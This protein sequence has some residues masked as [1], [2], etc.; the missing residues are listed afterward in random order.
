[1]VALVERVGDGLAEAVEGH[2]AV[3]L[4]FG[5]PLV[6]R[7]FPRLLRGDGQDGEIRAVAADLALF[8]IFPEEADELDVIEIHDV[9]LLFLPRFLGA[10]RAEWILLPRRAAAF[11]EGPKGFTG[12]NRESRSPEAAGRRNYPEAVPKERSGKKG[13][14]M[15]LTTNLFGTAAE[16]LQSNERSIIPIELFSSHPPSD[17]CLGSII[18]SV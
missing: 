1:M 10:P 7:V 17:F 6:V 13:N 5:L 15:D 16:G 12:R 11:W 8:R 14:L 3:P 9:I 2:D 4:G 18:P